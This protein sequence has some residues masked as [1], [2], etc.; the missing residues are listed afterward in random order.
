MRPHRILE[1]CLYAGDLAAAESFYARVLGLE[2]IGR[3]EGRHVFFRC[4]DG[5]LLI[6]DPAAT[7]ERGGQ[8]P[9]HG[10]KGPGHLAF[11][12]TASELI[13][14]REHLAR[15]QVEIEAEVGWPRGGRSIYF[16]DPAGNSIELA[17]PV[18]WGIDAG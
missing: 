11:A 13:G 3:V 14:W 4:G 10:A 17:E 6:F 5:V 1:S 7:A 16:R 12:V 2:V 15:A 9:P 8:A 18:M